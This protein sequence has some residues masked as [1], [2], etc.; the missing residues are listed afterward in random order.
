MFVAHILAQCP[1]QGA[2]KTFQPTTLQTSFNLPTTLKDTVLPSIR[3]EISA[4]QVE[5]HSFQNN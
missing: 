1:S 4:L 5:N 2:F 3:F